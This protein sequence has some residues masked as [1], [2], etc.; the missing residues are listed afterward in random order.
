MLQKINQLASIGQQPTLSLLFLVVIWILMPYAFVFILS[1]DFQAFRLV[2]QS[3]VTSHFVPIYAFSIIVL[4]IPHYFISL[5]LRSVLHPQKFEYQI[6]IYHILFFINV[7]IFQFHCANLKCG[8]AI[9]LFVHL[10]Y[11]S[12]N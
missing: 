12:S 11:S 1:I 5:A 4:F 6:G 9:L 3:H 10:C 7:V 2:Y 8:F